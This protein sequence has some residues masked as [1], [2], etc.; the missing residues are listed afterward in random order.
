MAL[1]ERLQ[2]DLVHDYIKRARRLLDISRVEAGNVE[3][4]PSAIDLS[5]LVHPASID[6]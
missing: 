4:K 2:D 3:L 6:G 5:E 1:L